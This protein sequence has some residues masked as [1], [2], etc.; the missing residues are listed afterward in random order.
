MDALGS[1]ADIFQLFVSLFGFKGVCMT[2]QGELKEHRKNSQA[3]LAVLIDADNA[4]PSVT[5]ALLDEIAKFG[6]ASVKRIYG[7]WT[8]PQLAGWKS[9]VLDYSIQSIQQFR[10][11]TGKN[12][13]DSAMII[14]AMDLL[15][16]RRFNGF[17]LV[18]SDSDFTRLAARIREEGIAVYGFGEQKTPKA[19]VSACD[20]FIYTEVLGTE[21]TTRSPQQIKTEHTANTTN[22]LKGDTK[23]VHLLRQAVDATSDENGWSQLSAVGSNIAQQAPDFDL[24]HF[25]CA[26]LGDLIKATEL[27]DIQH[28]CNERGTQVLS[29][30]DQR[31]KVGNKNSKSAKDTTDKQGKMYKPFTPAEWKQ[32]K[33][34]Y[35]EGDI[36]NGTIESVVWMG[37]FIAVTDSGV[38]GLLHKSNLPEDFMTCFTV[39]QKISITIKAISSEKQQIELERAVQNLQ[40]SENLRNANHVL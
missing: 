7:D 18:S 31:K 35:A 33:Q 28:K 24:K 6:R 32:F 4:K 8:T 17:C 1:I 20:Q 23:L 29:I 37:L 2:V 26:K 13:T 30:R 27:F 21:E 39:G 11:T 34:R 12:S 14:D 25:G 19:F 15:Y 40:E 9:L 3:M 36:C 22:T 16:T 38:T 10:Y 5:E